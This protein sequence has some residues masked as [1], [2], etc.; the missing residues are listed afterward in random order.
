[1][2]M[3]ALRHSFSNEG[4]PV[5]KAIEKMPFKAGIKWVLSLQININTCILSLIFKYDFSSTLSG[6]VMMKIILKIKQK[7]I[8]THLP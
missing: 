2:L 4:V 6:H 5:S 8:F 1:M 7:Y 3:P